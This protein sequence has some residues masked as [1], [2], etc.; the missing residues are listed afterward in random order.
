MKNLIA[1]SSLLLS[2]FVSA[3]AFADPTV[4]RANELG[5]EVHF[6][7][8][9]TSKVEETS[10]ADAY[11]YTGNA[12]KFNLS[13]VIDQPNCRGGVSRKDQFDCFFG[14]MD[15][16][17][18]LVTQSIKF[19]KAKE[20]VLISYLAYEQID[21]ASTKVHHVRILFADKGK[22]ADLHASVI[23][24]E[25]ADSAMLLGMNEAFSYSN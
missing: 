4:L 16:I 19:K 12:G 17:P 25:S 7:A 15:K 6:D 1:V 5:W 13:L 14:Q 23:K 24:P 21:G 8:P 9:P 20:A 18:G 11:H 22:W 3:A 2:L 10:S